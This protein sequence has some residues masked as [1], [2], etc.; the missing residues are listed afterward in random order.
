MKKNPI[1][2]VIIKFKIIIL[3]QYI[4]FENNIGYLFR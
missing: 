3:E 2:M 1:E 4:Y